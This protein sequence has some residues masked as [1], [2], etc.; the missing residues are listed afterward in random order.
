MQIND[1]Q[2]SD[3]AFPMASRGSWRAFGVTAVIAGHALALV[4]AFIAPWWLALAIL[5]PAAFGVVW[6]TLYPHSRLFGPVLRRLPESQR[7]IVW[8]TFDDGP[9][10]D[11]PALLDALDRYGAKAT[12]FLVGEKATQQPEH[13]CAIV[14]RGHTIGNHSNTHPAAAFWSLPPRAMREEIDRAQQTLTQLAGRA[15][16][17][18]RAVAGHANPFVEPVLRRL[19]LT[20][21]SWTARGFDSVDS[22]DDRVLH[23]LL[24]SLAPGAILLLHEDHTR[25]GRC[26][27]LLE[28]VLD[29][30]AA[31]GYSTVLPESL[32]ADGG[33]AATSN[34]LLNGVRPHSGEQSTISKPSAVSSARSP[35]RVG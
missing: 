10:A 14:E 11:T 12:F 34:Q 27:R 3:A 16:H 21:V 9:S 33:N 25:P 24:R 32:C 19:D 6:G 35:L 22:D 29:A 13:V 7:R 15:P 26:V 31:R 23:R 28:A 8:L 4:A 17:W 30:L 5:A 1:G 18:F 2:A 20:R